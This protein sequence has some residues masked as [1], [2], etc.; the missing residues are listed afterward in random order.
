[1]MAHDTCFLQQNPS[2]QHLLA[3]SLIVCCKKPGVRQYKLKATSSQKTLS[4]FK[5]LLLWQGLAECSSGFDE[6]EKNFILLY[7]KLSAN[8]LRN[9][10]LIDPLKA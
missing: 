8:Y 4:E 9:N 5:G 6:Q 7:S 10:L 3:S 2:G 1:M